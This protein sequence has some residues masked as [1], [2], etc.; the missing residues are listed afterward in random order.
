MNYI[1]LQ[2]VI[3]PVSCHILEELYCLNKFLKDLN[4]SSTHHPAAMFE[5]P[6]ISTL[7]LYACI[8]LFSTS[9]T[10]RHNVQ[11]GHYSRMC[12]HP[13]GIYSMSFWSFLTLYNP[14]WHSSMF[15]AI[16]NVCLL[17]S[18]LSLH[19]WTIYAFPILLYT[20]SMCF[21]PFPTFYNL[22]LTLFI[23]AV[24]DI[25]IFWLFIV[26]VACTITIGLEPD[27]YRLLVI[28]EP[29]NTILTPPRLFLLTFYLPLPFCTE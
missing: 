19:W 15:Y 13:L 3:E 5:S 16:F 8:W 2:N 14:Y 24:I 12:F 10:F 18:D 17:I 4:S 29:S 7:P 26:L 11:P 21:W 23:F 25:L 27:P 6:L 22:L 9:T 1:C 20:Y 28:S